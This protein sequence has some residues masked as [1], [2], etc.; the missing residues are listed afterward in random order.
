LKGDDE[1][2]DVQSNLALLATL[3]RSHVGEHLGEHGEVLIH[4]VDVH[5]CAAWEV[6]SALLEHHT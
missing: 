4:P 6:D 2:Q 3:H 5:P 1:L